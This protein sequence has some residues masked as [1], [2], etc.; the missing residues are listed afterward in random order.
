MNHTKYYSMVR[1]VN[2]HFQFSRLFVSVSLWPH[3]KKHA[4]PPCRI[5]NSRSLLKLMLVESEMPSTHLILCCPLL[6][7][8]SSSPSIRIFPVSQFFWT[9]LCVPPIDLCSFPRLGASIWSGLSSVSAFLL[10]QVLRW[11]MMSVFV[12]NVFYSPFGKNMCL[13]PS[14]YAGLGSCT[15][16]FSRFASRGCSSWGSAGFW[17]QWLVAERGLLGSG[18]SSCGS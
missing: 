4:R 3:G 11:Q 10:V 13:F 2:I 7:P 16:A 1:I 17:L 12:W 9:C 8:P 15:Q 5:T 18:F 14:G 6:L